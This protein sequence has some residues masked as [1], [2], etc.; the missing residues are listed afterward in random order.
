MLYIIDAIYNSIWS[1]PVDRKSS[2]FVFVF[3]EKLHKKTKLK[4]RL[5]DWNILR[6]NHYKK[7]KTK[8]ESA[9]QCRRYKRYCL[10]SW[11]RKI[12]WR[13]AWQPTPVFLPEES[14]GQR[15]LADNSPTAAAA[16]LLQ[17]SS[18]LWDPIDGSPPGS[19]VPGI[20]QA[21]ILEWVAISFS[22][23]WKW[24]VKVK[25]LSHVQFFVTPW[26]VAYQA[27]PSMEF[28]W[29]EYCSGLPF[30]SPGNS[31]RG[32]ETQTQL[33]NW[34]HTHIHIYNIIF[35]GFPGGL[36]VKNSPAN[37][38]DACSVPE[39]VRSPGEGNGNALQYSWLRNPMDTTTTTTII[40]KLHLPAS[41]F[42]IF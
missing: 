26:T 40:V 1:W 22:S 21:R 36:E 32:T 20:L 30:P 4:G 31:P 39:L 24:K 25:S 8:P 28:S 38:R 13:R 2:G 29:Q 18:T 7:T 14:R 12:P 5:K 41:L 15:T 19:P 35:K 16:K 9:C 42:A 27:P 37:A 33:S 17:S 6:F 34:V 3:L 11:V 10:D 23:A